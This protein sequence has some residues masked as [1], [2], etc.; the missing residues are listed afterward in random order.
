M[1][2]AREGTMDARRLLVG[3]V[4][5]AIGV[6]LLGFLIYEVIFGSYFEGQTL[7]TERE[8]PVVWAMILAALAHGLLLTLVIGW[9]NTWSLVGG[10]KTGAIVGLLLWLG[11]DMILFSLVEYTTAAG[12]LADAALAVV[13]YGIAGAAIAAVAKGGSTTQTA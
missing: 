10:F 4:V 6:A 12:G 5:G 13:Q 2:Q 7:V 11:A 1:P 3:S 8:A 9:A